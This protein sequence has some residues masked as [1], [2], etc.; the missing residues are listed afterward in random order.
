MDMTM[1]EIGLIALTISSGIGYVTYVCQI[2]K[3]A[4]SKTSAG[5]SL[6]SWLLTVLG[7]SLYM[8]YAVTQ[9]NSELMVTTG[10]RL[11]LVLVTTGLI[12]HYRPRKVRDKNEH[13]VDSAND[14]L[15]EL[16]GVETEI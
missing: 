1:K 2:L 4:K 16:S 14:E 3:T 5:C 12:I 9:I 13:I 7:Q 10:I 8:L 6:S 15:R 11:V